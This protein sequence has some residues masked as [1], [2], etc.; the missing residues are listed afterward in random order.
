MTDVQVK[1]HR[2]AECEDCSQTNWGE[3]RQDILNAIEK[4]RP[5]G[6]L[7]QE[8]ADHMTSFFTECSDDSLATLLQIMIAGMG[9]AHDMAEMI[10]DAAK[11]MADV[12]MRMAPRSQRSRLND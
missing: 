5:V 12:I 1:Y 2:V 11:S 8:E 10:S 4:C 9:Q 6:T 7:T 3:I